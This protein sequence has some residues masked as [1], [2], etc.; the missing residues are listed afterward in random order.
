MKNY[1]TKSFLPLLAVCLGL[2]ISAVLPSHTALA[3]TSAEIQHVYDEADLLS[4]SEA[5]EVEDM[6]SQYSEKDDLDIIILTHKDASAVDAETYIENFYDSFY[7]SR[8]S[9]SVILLIDL[10]NRVVFIE[11]YGFAKTSINSGRIDSIIDEITPDLSNGDYSAAF[12]QFIKL[13]DHYINTAPIY[14]NVWLHLG[15]ALAIGGITVAVMAYN[16]GG[17]MT[18]GGNTYLEP[19]NSGLIGRRDDYIRTLITRVRKP[20]NN[21]GG[22]GGGRIS[23]GGHSH[24]SGGGRF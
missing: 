1:F 11:G 2:T 9:D 5:K 8:R 15:I 18:V 17:R 24:S 16:A 3:N 4:S 20:Q 12:R 10:Y 7:D 19:G 14:L 21:N 22:G 13:S 23:A 6:C